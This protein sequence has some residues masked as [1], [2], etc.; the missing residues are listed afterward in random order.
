MTH[1]DNQQQAPVGSAAVSAPAAGG[2]ST[3]SRVVNLPVSA[4]TPGPAHNYLTPN[5][6]SHFY[7]QPPPILPPHPSLFAPR[8]SPPAAPPHLIALPHPAAMRFGSASASPPLVLSSPH[9]PA[10]APAHVNQPPPPLQQYHMHHANTANTA[11]RT[12]GVMWPWAADG[13]SAAQGEGGSHSSASRQRSNPPPMYIPIERTLRAERKRYYDVLLPPGANVKTY[14]LAEGIINRTM[15][16]TRAQ[17]LI[18]EGADPS[19]TVRVYRR[20]DGDSGMQQHLL[21]ELALD[22]PAI[23]KTSWDPEA[24]LGVFWPDEAVGVAVVSAMLEGGA[25]VNAVLPLAVARVNEALVD[26]AIKHN[27]DLRVLK[28]GPGRRWPYAL[29]CLL[30][31]RSCAPI[32]LKLVKLSPTLVTDDTRVAAIKSSWS[33]RGSVDEAFCDMLFDKPHPLP[34]TA[35]PSLVHAAPQHESLAAFRWLCRKNRAATM[36]FINTPDA[37]FGYN[38]AL[39]PLGKFANSSGSLRDEAEASRLIREMLTLG[40]SYRIRARPYIHTAAR[41]RLCRD[42][43]REHLADLWG[44]A[45]AAINGALDAMEQLAETLIAANEDMQPFAQRIA[46]FLA[47]ISKDAIEDQ[48]QLGRR[49]NAGIGRF[50]RAAAPLFAVG[51]IN[52]LRSDA[53][54]SLKCLVMGRVEGR[55]LSVK[56]LVVQAIAD[57]EQRVAGPPN[58]A[59]FKWDDVGYVM[60]CGGR[61]VFEPMHLEALEDRLPGES[62]GLPNIDYLPPQ[63]PIRAAQRE[64]GAA[65]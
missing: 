43:H 10:P 4:A 7:P 48:T 55:K 44:H 17:Q 51:G 18:A 15:T 25:D 34:P 33:P 65:L 27:A 59:P 19:V 14:Q 8:P 52:A 63:F 41:D 36:A 57:E 39:T 49:V 31:N 22:T 16:P 50:I 26:M 54:S 24:I 56:D 13:S 2:P 53:A 11:G 45:E 6:P 21:I 58:S 28:A 5:T 46:A 3:T 29:D 42:A 61:Q 62:L 60:V 20:Q 32:F 64:S 37:S 23:D 9:R 35:F 12:G 47:P 30:R 1:Q 40:A 38:H